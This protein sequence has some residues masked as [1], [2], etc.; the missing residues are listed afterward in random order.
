MLPDYVVWDR[1]KIEQVLNNLLSNA[2]KF[3]HPGSTVIVSIFANERDIKI[4]VDDQG[5]GLPLDILEQL[6]V[7]FSKAGRIGTHGEKSTGLGLT[8]ARRIVEGHG[9]DIRAENL[10]EGGTRFVISLPIGGR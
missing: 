10:P 8:I 1:P 7:P 6:F 9:G 2:V 4:Q 5:T 3:S